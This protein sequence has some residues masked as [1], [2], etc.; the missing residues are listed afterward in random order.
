MD[1]RKFRRIA[2]IAQRIYL[3]GSVIFLNLFCFGSVLLGIYF[4]GYNENCLGRAPCPTSY[5]TLP[6]IYLIV[7]AKLYVDLLVVVCRCPIPLLYFTLG[8]CHFLAHGGGGGV[9][10]RNGMKDS[11]KFLIPPGNSRKIVDPPSLFVKISCDPPLLKPPPPKVCW[12]YNDVVPTC[13]GHC[14]CQ[15]EVCGC[16][17]VP[18]AEP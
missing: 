3:L 2:Q 6:E 12:V 13:K 7:L 16:C 14:P 10:G 5:S 1:D 9:C 4:F 18:R 15:L 8:S 11:V 17:K